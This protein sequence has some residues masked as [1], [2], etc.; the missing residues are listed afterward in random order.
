MISRVKSAPS[1]Q[2]AQRLRASVLFRRGSSAILLL[3]VFSTVVSVNT[4]PVITNDSLAYLGHSSDFSTYGLVNVGY[5]QIG[6]PLALALFRTVGKALTIEP[7]LFSSIVQKALLL[8]SIAIAIRLW[9][10]MAAGLL[11]FLLCASTLAYPNF[12]LTEGL[13]VPLAVLLALTLV[14]FVTHVDEWAITDPWRLWRYASCVVAVA[15]ALLSIRY[16]FVV[17]GAAPLALVWASWKTGFRKP[18]LCLFG[19]YLVF[20]GC[21]SYGLS[22]ENANE[23]DVFFPTVRGERSA[24]WA[25]WSLVFTLNPE[26]ADDPDLHPFYD[27]GTPYTYM[28]EVDGSGLSYRDQ[29][30]AYDQAIDDLLR[31]AGLSPNLSRLESFMWALRGGRLDDVRGVAE[32]IAGSN[33]HNVDQVINSNQ[34]ARSEGVEAFSDRFNE[35]SLP[36]AVLTSAAGLRFPLPNGQ[37]AVSYLLPIAL[38]VMA[39]GT[40]RSETR[41]NALVGLSVVIAYAA[42]MGAVRADNYRFL[43]TTTA[44]GLVI[45]TGV[46]HQLLSPWRTRQLFSRRT[47]K[48][49]LA[50][51]FAEQSSD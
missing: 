23:Y 28:G 12:I 6:Y 36:E 1:D 21:L 41:L 40:A 30:A 48:N 31:A 38:L 13:S 16:P 32:R 19:T 47:P 46:G 4:F 50:A 51:G 11:V 27:D 43:I 20:A 26:N 17:F 3:I 33:R 39:L 5:R 35:G 49:A 7:L 34:F 18:S 25:T 9:K 8:L 22:V 10:W 24:Y 42:A 2:S 45:A 37:S 29:R 15:A 14:S 44:F